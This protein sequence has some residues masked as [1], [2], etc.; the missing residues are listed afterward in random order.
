MHLRSAI[1]ILLETDVLAAS[2]DPGDPH[3][4]EARG[5]VAEYSIV[6]SSYAL[7]ELY[8]LVRSNVIAD[9]FLSSSAFFA[10]SFP[11]LSSRMNKVSRTSFI[12]SR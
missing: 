4:S 9:L 3:Y 11:L 5:I 10:S 1:P 2:I 8:L 6:L 7:L 12:A